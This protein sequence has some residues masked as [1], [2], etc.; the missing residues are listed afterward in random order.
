[1]EISEVKLAEILAAHQ[2]WLDDE[3]TGC[4]ADLHNLNLSGACFKNANLYLANFTGANLQYADL[5]G[6]DLSSADLR[7][8]NLRRAN[9]CHAKLQGTNLYG[10]CLNNADLESIDA[11]GAILSFADLDGTTLAHANLKNTNFA[12][13]RLNYADLRGAILHR[14]NFSQADLTNQSKN[15]EGADFRATDL[16]GA[17]LPEDFYQVVGS[18]KFKRCTTYDRVNDQI[19]HGG[20]INKGKNTIEVFKE[21]IKNAHEAEDKIFG[22][23]YFAEYL[24]AIQYFEAIRGQKLKED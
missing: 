20:W 5:S 16:T 17:K 9:L 15:L 6:A 10:A 11:I 13:A 12:S 21:H 23:R 24:A 7:G 8:A 22:P 1:M 14:A 4:Q 18:G 3:D 2:K 19:I